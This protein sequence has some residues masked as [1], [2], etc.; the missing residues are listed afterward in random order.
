[1]AEKAKTFSWDEFK[2]K[3]VAEK[4]PSEKI[5]GKAE[6]EKIDAVLKDY[7]KKAE[8]I[9]S[10]YFLYWNDLEAQDKKFG[11]WHKA[12]INRIAVFNK[13]ANCPHP[14]IKYVSFGNESIWFMGTS[15]KSA[16]KWNF[17]KTGEK[18]PPFFVEDG[19]LMYVEDFIL[20]KKRKFKDFES[21][22]K[23]WDESHVPFKGKGFYAVSYKTMFVFKGRTNI[24]SY[25]GSLSEKKFLEMREIL[26]KSSEKGGNN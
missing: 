15:N 26:K 3:V 20:L 12:Q 6:Q 14:G 9:G 25:R 8:S 23:T 7:E 10:V 17:H 11:K 5:L 18:T 13:D 16:V 4:K 2:A 21:F 1:M 22:K 24:K 19:S